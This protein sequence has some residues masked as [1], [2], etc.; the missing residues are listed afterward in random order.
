MIRQL[1]YVIAVLL[2]LGA[3]AVQGVWTDRWSTSQELENAAARLEQVP[4]SF[5]DWV[6]T[7]QEFDAKEYARAGIVGGLFRRYTNR[8]TGATVSVLIVCG[9]SGPISVHTPDVCYKGAGYSQL[10]NYERAPVE[11]TKDNAFWWLRMQKQNT[12]IPEYLG[13]HFAWSPDGEWHATPVD[14]ARF[15]YAKYPYLY[16]LY[17]VRDLATT[18]GSAEAAEDIAFIGQFIPELRKAL[19]PSQPAKPDAA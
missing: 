1:P 3:G 9:R 17:V 8:E 2:V 15:T 19:F 12:I 14:A 6:G 7:A 16:K 4:M 5:G 11:G 18:E 10:A 13:I